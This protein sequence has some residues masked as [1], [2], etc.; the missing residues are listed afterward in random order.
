MQRIT[1][2]GDKSVVISGRRG[3]DARYCSRRRAVSAARLRASERCAC[4]RS[5]DSRSI[6]SF[7]ELVPLLLFLLEGGWN[8]P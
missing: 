4:S 2:G 6:A 8:V 7:R 1:S 3:A 5:S